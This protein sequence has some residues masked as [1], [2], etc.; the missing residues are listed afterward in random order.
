MMSVISFA[1]IGKNRV[2]IYLQEFVGASAV[3]HVTKDSD[4]ALFGLSKA[5]LEVPHNDSLSLKS[6]DSS[7]I[8]R[9]SVR[10][11]FILHDAMDRLV[12]RLLQHHPVEAPPMNP[13]ATAN[14]AMFFWACCVLWKM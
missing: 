6:N 1:V 7:K 8:M 2:P 12:Q 13:N 3:D 10:Q 14:D 4:A 9:C 11:Q 5:A